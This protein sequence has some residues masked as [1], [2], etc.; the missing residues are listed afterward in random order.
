MA[1]NT[2]K[3]VNVITKALLNSQTDYVMFISASQ[4]FLKNH[5]T[6]HAKNRVHVL[7]EGKN[8]HKNFQKSKL[9]LY[10]E[11]NLQ[12]SNNTL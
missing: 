11:L 12:C 9:E 2:M 7:E 6:S 8:V 3:Y 1:A 4:Q 5:A 10:Q